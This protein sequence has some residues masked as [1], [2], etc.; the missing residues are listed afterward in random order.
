[1]DLE[2]YYCPGKKTLFV[3]DDLCGKFTVD[4]KM[5]DDWDS[6]KDLVNQVIHD[7]LCKMLFS[8]RFQV[9]KDPQFS[10]LEWFTSCECNIN[11]EEICL[12]ENEKE[13][14]FK[15]YLSSEILEKEILLITHDNFPF[16]CAQYSKSDTDLA[17]GKFFKTPYSAYE[18]ELN[19]LETRRKK[20]LCGL[21]LCIIFN[22]QLKETYFHNQLPYFKQIVK[23]I[24]SQIGLA[25]STTATCLRIELD[26]LEKTYV[27]KTDG[28]YQITH[29]KLFDFM[30]YY[31]GKKIPVCFINHADSGLIRERFLWKDGFRSEECLID[32]IVYLQNDYL[33]LYIERMIKDWRNGKVSDV[34]YNI[35]MTSS[36]FRKTFLNY[37]KDIDEKEAQVLADMEDC[38]SVGLE[39]GN[40][41]LILACINSYID[42][43]S[44]LIKNKANVNYQRKDG[45]S[46]L[47]IACEK[48]QV[49]VVNIL[50]QNN[51][52]ANICTNEGSSPLGYA[53][54]SH[55][56]SE[57][58]SEI[59]TKLL[60][61][62]A[63]VNENKYKGHN[64]TPLFL[65]CQKDSVP[66]AKILL[67]HKSDPNICLNNGMSALL[68]ACHKN[69]IEMVGLLLEGKAN[70]NIEKIDGSSP[71]FWASAMGLRD[72]TELLLKK[73]AIIDQCV[74]DKK[75]IEKSFEGTP[76]DLK[77]LKKASVEIVKYFGSPETKKY[78]QGI[79]KTKL[80]DLV[81]DVVAGSTPLHM[82][83]FMGKIEI[84]QLLAT[85]AEI[86]NR[87]KKNSITPFVYAHAIGHQEIIDILLEKGAD[88]TF[89]IRH[90]NI[91]RYS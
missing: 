61:R 84:V 6:A 13:L 10:R 89:A 81:F 38:L 30:A 66:I 80:L 65:A 64:M 45:A 58:I 36:T 60:N 14:I 68:V 86:V 25:K 62:N 3:I 31:F 54:S 17:I 5:T 22:N 73:N 34:I 87:S 55:G 40:T 56:D 12:T 16:L 21:C 2:N 63:S 4:K 79:G 48:G 50:L 11:S 20:K 85:N 44:W 57:I 90:C 18:K 67:Q 39:S 26:T 69:S 78:I 1:M 42:L 47:C 32:N 53:C 59:I 27:K 23:D 29:D 71:L 46:A 51:A 88:Q 37:L 19:Q 28:L 9:Y 70:P 52:D 74:Y 75:D 82:A 7:P 15:S 49:D 76:K 83:C 41:A 33:S 77:K 8:C 35:N 72:I 43:L 91:A 24:C